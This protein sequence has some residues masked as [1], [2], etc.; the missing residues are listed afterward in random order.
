MTAVESLP[1]YASA[2][3]NAYAADVPLDG[4]G[5]PLFDID[6]SKVDVVRPKV[7]ATTGKHVWPEGFIDD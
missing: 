5:Y 2:G 1:A 3:I 7:D 4:D 6:E